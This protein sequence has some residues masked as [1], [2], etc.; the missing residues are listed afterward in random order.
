MGRIISIQEERQWRDTGLRDP[1]EKGL[2]P[3]GQPYHGRSDAFNWRKHPQVM[4]PALIKAIRRCL[5]VRLTCAHPKL[6]TKIIKD[7]ISMLRYFKEKG[8]YHG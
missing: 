1:R 7:D 3:Y 8:L 4:I 5:R 6:M 2:F